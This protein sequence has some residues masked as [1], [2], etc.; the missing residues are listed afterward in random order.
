MSDSSRTSD[1]VSVAIPEV[2]APA[3]NWECARAAVENGA[4]AIYFGLNRFN[5][6]M[7]AGNFTTETLPELMAF[8]HERGV[9]GYLTFNTLTFADELEEAAEFLEAAMRAGV[10][11]AIV[12][13]VGICR[14]IRTLSPDFPIHASTQMTVTSDAGVAFAEELGAE[15]VVLAREN[16]IPE[17]GKIL[18]TRPV[19]AAPMKLEVFVHGALCV[20][21]SGQCLTSEALGGRS[22][23]RGECAQACRLP[24][25]LV[26]DGAVTPL[27]DRRYLLS[28]QDL[29]GLDLIPQLVE[30]GIA[31]LKIEGRLKTPEYVASI[32]RLYREAVDRA[33]GISR[34]GPEP[35]PPEEA[36]YEMEMTFSRGL[37]TG[38]LGG[39]DN[40]SLVHARFPK[41]RGVFL[42]EVRQVTKDAV[43]VAALGPVQPGDGV[44]FDEGQPDA[45]ETGGHVHRVEVK[46][47]L[48]WIGFRRKDLDW[49]R[50]SVGAKLWK[51]S[52]PQLAKQLR[53]SFEGE[54]IRFRRPVRAM[55]TGTEGS[56][57]R[58]RLVDGRGIEVS[59]ESQAAL[60][61]AENRPLTTELLSK[62][63]GRL[64]GTP[65]Y[66][67]AL[68][69]QLPEGLLLPISELN[70]LRREAVEALCAR[71]RAGRPWT[72]ARSGAAAVR[73]LRD[74]AQTITA[75]HRSSAADET[76]T[77]DAPFEFVLMVR[78]LEQL[79]A[80][81]PLAH[82]DVYAEF[83]DPKR[84]REAMAK[85]R[86]YREATG[87]AVDLWV[88]PP[89]IFKPGEEW[90]TKIIRSA[91]ADGYLVRN[92]EHLRAFAEAGERCRG[93]FSLNVANPFT[94][95]YLLDR[96]KLEGVTASYD[97]NIAQLTA[98]LTSAPPAWF[99]VTLHQ[100]MPLFHMEHCVFCAF[101]SEG[102]DYRT[103][104]R[105]C[106]KH[107]VRLRD[108]VGQE[109]LLR[110]DAG[111]RN[112]VFNARTQTGAEF[113]PH[114]QSLGQRR[115]RLEF[116]EESPDEIRALIDRYTQIAQGTLE[117]DALW[118]EFKLINQLGVTRGALVNVG[119]VDRRMKVEG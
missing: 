46:N 25:D 44:V 31:S 71:R 85:V 60:E 110:A 113:M 115:F 119:K 68:E 91:E 70:Q 86:A 73:L 54:Q 82:R 66:L 7:R 98:L 40:Q 34:P 76:A 117:P 63:L 114:L 104:G 6:R 75:A 64:G 103:C 87:R 61:R 112:T 43:A 92:H 81:L 96:Y 56:P 47:G 84:Y 9:R 116:L 89:R 111:C 1:S 28:P 4:D 38:W 16:T 36:R 26:T 21:Y 99:E 58:L 41:K 94:A 3:G 17:I 50:I 105:P 49:N 33:A 79:D 83:E 62:Q 108:R 100:H 20:A 93:D 69:N 88:A 8:L 42:G 12:Q 67:E 90:V 32:T 118:R 29:A 101:L 35:T 97:L 13:D 107:R 51:T 11:A 109:H 78:E 55:V 2:L 27:G 22:A 102:K 23:N 59:A 10:D 30:I 45:E 74:E 37:Y 14:L 18:A 15:V 5:A 106:E 95:A 57:L 52:D 48:T 39:L 77:T 19:E 80:V 72:L 24:Y 65:F 53:Q